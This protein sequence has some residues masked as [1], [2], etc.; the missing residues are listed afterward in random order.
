M[1]TEISYKGRTNPDRDAVNDCLQYLGKPAAFKELARLF[2]KAKGPKDFH[3]LNL[4]C[5]FRGISGLPF[6]ALIR[7]YAGKDKF[8]AYWDSGLLD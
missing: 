8:Q 6:F 2:K 7:R 1:H 3:Q 4:L 5:S